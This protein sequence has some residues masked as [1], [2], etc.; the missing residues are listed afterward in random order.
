M[1]EPRAS[2][3]ILVIK[4]TSLG[5]VVHATAALRAIRRAHPDAHITVLTSTSARDVFRHSPDVDL[6][7]AF[8]RYRVKSHWWR[9]PSWT[10]AH[11]RET[12]RAVRKR[13]YDLAFDLQG[14]WKTVI[15]LWAAQARVRFVK[16]R[17]WF[18]RKF[19]QPQLHALAEMAGV[20][21]LAGIEA[22]GQQMTLCIST[23]EEAAVTARLEA[24]GAAA[25]RLVVFCPLTRWPTKNWPIDRFVGLAAKLPA[26]CF[27]VFAGVEADRAAIAEASAKLPP[28][29]GGSLAG[30]L[31][32]L[33]FF[34]LIHQA[35]AVV[36]GDSLA[37][38][39]AQALRRPLVALFGPTDEGRVGPRGEDSV[40]VR[41]QV[42]CRRCYRRRHCSRNCIGRVSVD[43]V[44]GA[45][46]RVLHPA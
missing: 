39:V 43:Q 21:A 8:D 37:L 17:W 25:R 12:F 32:L 36:T 7:L 11:F 14:S 42:D 26:D 27:V 35:D 41:A 28:A 6:L 4:Q 45:L 30:D 19:R 44:A 2:M 16:G 5:D 10:L 33:E 40:V 3:N 29:R 20:L 18:A 34:A 23:A 15:F 24:L 31:S 9:Q 38:H 46:T 22:G 13:H 1:T